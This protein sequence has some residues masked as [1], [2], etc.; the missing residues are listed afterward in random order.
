LL[1]GLTGFGDVA[2]LLPLAATIFLWLQLSGATRAAAWWAFSVAVCIAV[3]A[4][5]KIFLWG[6]PPISG[7]RSPSGHVSLSVLVYGATVFVIAVEGGTLRPSIAV[8]GGMALILAI[9]A[10]RLL[11]DAHTVPEVMI[12]WVVGSASVALFARRY[13]RLRPKNARLG[14]LLVGMTVVAFVLHGAEVHAEDLL[15]RITAFLRID[16]R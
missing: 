14:P 16:C 11:L 6:C 8:A 1:V 9:A 15:H 3:T 4:V 12:G 7:L 13:R 5:S 2:L 10:S